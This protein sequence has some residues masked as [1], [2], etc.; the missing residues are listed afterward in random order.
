MIFVTNDPSGHK[1]Y[2]ENE[3]Y[4]RMNGDKEVASISGKYIPDPVNLWEAR[5][6]AHGSEQ[7]LPEYRPT[8]ATFALFKHWE[9]VNA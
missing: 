6:R 1:W 7:C 4:I 5:S 8:D 3:K 9:E 2:Y